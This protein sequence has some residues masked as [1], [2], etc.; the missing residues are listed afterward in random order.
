MQTLTLKKQ[1]ENYKTEKQQ[2]NISDSRKDNILR[3]DTEVT[4]M[5]KVCIHTT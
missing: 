3:E 2:K 1:H 5:E 4:L